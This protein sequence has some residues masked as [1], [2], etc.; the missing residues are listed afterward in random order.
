V[1]TLIW[2]NAP[3]IFGTTVSPLLIDS[4][5]VKAQPKNNRDANAK[6]SGFQSNLSTVLIRLTPT[7]TARG[8][9]RA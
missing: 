6:R 4:V 3:E 1:N 8:G 5:S 7:F 2:I 9:I